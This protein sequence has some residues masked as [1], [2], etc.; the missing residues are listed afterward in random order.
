MKILNQWVGHQWDQ[1]AFM[2]EHLAPIMTHIDLPWLNQ[3]LSA[4]RDFSELFVIDLQGKVIS[5]THQAHI[6]AADLANAAWTEGLKKPFLH[7]PYIDPLTLDIGAS[8]SNFHDEV[9]LMFYQPI[10]QNGES[11]G[12]ICGRVPND[13]LGDLI[14][15]EAGHIYPES[16]DNY[17]FMVDSHFDQSI[18]QGTALS[19]SRFE[20]DTFS[21]GE[22]LK[23][24][25]HTR[26]GTVSVKRHTELELRFTDPATGQLH[27]GVRETIRNGD[28]LFIT[29]PG[30]SDYRHI[31]VIGKGVTFQLKGSP[32]AWV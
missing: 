27:P 5:S 17:I 13:V 28:H 3:R 9:T 12:A 8:S 25:V 26:W 22:N 24:G 2:A 21:H 31:P 29:Y 6:G 4:S 32:T 19:R 14:Q 18:Q 15:R 23:S 7:G 1:L 10:Q 11:I 20:D 16:G 30:Y